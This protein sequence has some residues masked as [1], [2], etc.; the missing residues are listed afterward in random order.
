MYGHLKV[1]LLS[2]TEAN[3]VWTYTSVSYSSFIALCLLNIYKVDNNTLKFKW[4]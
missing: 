4:V 2:N 3:I 1:K